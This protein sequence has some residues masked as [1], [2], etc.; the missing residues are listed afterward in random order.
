MLCCTGLLAGSGCAAVLHI[1]ANLIPHYIYGLCTAQLQQLLV[2][3]ACASRKVGHTFLDGQH[4][5][6]V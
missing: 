5:V 3:P 2:G 6:G 1:S 4:A